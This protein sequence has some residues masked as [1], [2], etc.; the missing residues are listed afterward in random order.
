MVYILGTNP[1]TPSTSTVPTQHSSLCIV[2]NEKCYSMPFI[3][4]SFLQEQVHH[5]FTSME[6]TECQE[7]HVVCHTTFLYE[8]TRIQRCARYILRLLHLLNG[9]FKSR[10]ISILNS[11]LHACES[12]RG[13]GY[14]EHTIQVYTYVSLPQIHQ[15]Q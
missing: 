12:G 15:T 10:N 5:F 4:C 11:L 14:K 9:L 6:A 13:P 2:T 8:T 1:K 3:T 7:T